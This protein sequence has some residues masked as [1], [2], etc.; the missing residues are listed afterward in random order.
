ME[1]NNTNSHLQEI[2]LDGEEIRWLGR[3]KAFELLGADTKQEIVMT[4]GISIAVFVISIFLL[5]PAYLSGALTLSK[6]LVLF[7]IAMF[8]P[9][10]LSYRPFSDKKCLEEESFYAIT[11]LRVI[12]IVKGEVKMIPLSKQVKAAVE[13][14]SQGLG[15]LSIGTAV[16]HSPKKGRMLAVVGR[17]DSDDLNVTE[18]LLFYNVEHPES[19][20]AYFA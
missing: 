20:M 7:T 2:L 17:R 14:Q 3:P 15:N 13:N 12:A 18:G 1:W 5:I 19:L 9:V 10:V 11:N 16:G 6:S 4:W 8:L